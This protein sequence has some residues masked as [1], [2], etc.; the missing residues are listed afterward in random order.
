MQLR[1]W[2]VDQALGIFSS[3]DDFK[4]PTYVV[5]TAKDTAPRRVPTS[6]DPMKLAAEIYDFVA[7]PALEFKVEP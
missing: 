6:I 1:K 5:D 4:N 3:S 2:A 7:K